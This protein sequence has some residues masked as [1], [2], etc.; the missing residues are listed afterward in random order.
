MP[1]ARERAPACFCYND[2]VSQSPG[3]GAE[4]ADAKTFY[5]IFSL[6]NQRS[7]HACAPDG[8]IQDKG[9]IADIDRV[10]CLVSGGA[11]SVAMLRLLHSLSRSKVQ[12]GRGDSPL[13]SAT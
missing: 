8:F 9:L 11:D 12:D 5:F 13:A 6:D 1:V 10:L 2:R 7:S 3:G 4:R